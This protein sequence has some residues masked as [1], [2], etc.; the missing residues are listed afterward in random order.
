MRLSGGVSALFTEK[1]AGRNMINTA[2]DMYQSVFNNSTDPLVRE[3]ALYRRRPLPRNRS[4]MCDEARKGLRAT[5]QG[6]SE[7]LVC[8]S[9]QGAVR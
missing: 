5:A 3:H 6:F 9:S 8:G 4:A 1:A 2:L 7:R